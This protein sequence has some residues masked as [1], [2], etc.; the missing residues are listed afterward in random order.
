MARKKC[1]VSWS[2]YGYGGPNDYVYFDED[3]I[4]IFQKDES[5]RISL[6]EKYYPSFRGRVTS[7]N[8]SGYIENA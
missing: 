6:V 1:R 5:F 4:G 8:V 7:A 3:E 2:G